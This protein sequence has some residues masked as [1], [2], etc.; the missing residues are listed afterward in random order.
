MLDTM[1][2]PDP[3][4]DLAVELKKSEDEDKFTQVLS[5]MKY[6]DP[7]FYYSINKET[8][9]TIIK[10]MGELHLEIIIDRIKRESGI[11]LNVGSPQVSYR[12]K[13]TKEVAHHEILDQVVAGKALFAA[14]E[15]RVSP[16]PENLSQENIVEVKFRPENELFKTYLNIVKASIDDFLKSGVILGYP[17][18]GAKIEVLSMNAD[19]TRSN[20]VSFKVATTNAL[21]RAFRRG[22][23]VLMWPMMELELTAPSEYSGDVISS[24]ASRGGNVL[25]VETNNNIEIINCKAPLSELFGYSTVIRS[26]TQGRGTF[27]MKFS[28]YETLDLAKTKKILE[29]KGMSYLFL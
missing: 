14:V 26:C 23:P 2:F 17:I 10:G 7:T 21:N 29:S 27:T 9:Q 15:L 1:E 24:I 22:A 20:D 4:M 18:L 12:E 16:I 13:I 8:G 3:V 25:G 19:E 11:G 28:H 6:E 5:N